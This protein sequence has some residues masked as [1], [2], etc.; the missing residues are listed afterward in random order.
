MM[1][2]NKRAIG[3]AVKSVRAWIKKEKP[4]SDEL[5]FAYQFMD[6]LHLDFR[7]AIDAIKPLILLRK[8][9]TGKLSKSRRR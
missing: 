2:D 5:K 9:L 8:R 3:K 4:T 1:T 7:D 6:V